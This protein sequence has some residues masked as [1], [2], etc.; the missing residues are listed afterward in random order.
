MKKAPHENDDVDFESEDE[1]GSVGAAKAKLQKLK[2]ELEKVKTERQEYLDG[3]QRAKADAINLKRETERQA[4]RT[5]ERLR[6]ALVHDLIP[7]L[8]SFDMAATSEQWGMLDDGWRGGMEMVRDQLIDALRSHGIER[9]GKVGQKFDHNLHE[10][11]EERDDVVGES[12][13]IVRVL[14]SGYKTN[15]RVLRPAQVIVRK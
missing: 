15:E 13:A 6:E 9:Y 8:D 5:S 1:L 2:D 10:A 12:G 14:R 7:A 3:W 4:A 11:V